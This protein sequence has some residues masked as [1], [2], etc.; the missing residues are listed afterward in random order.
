MLYWIDGRTMTLCNMVVEV[1]GKNGVILADST[2]FN[3]LKVCVFET[4]IDVLL[5]HV[6]HLYWPF[7]GHFLPLCQH[8]DLKIICIVWIFL[9]LIRVSAFLSIMGCLTTST[10]PFLSWFSIVFLASRCNTPLSYVLIIHI[11]WMGVCGS[12]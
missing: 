5:S 1:G 3:Y 9:A 11:W 12:P 4:E 7:A 10:C 8:T 6:M 2:T